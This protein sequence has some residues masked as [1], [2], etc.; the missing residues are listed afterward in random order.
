MIDIYLHCTCSYGIYELHV[1][2]IYTCIL[3]VHT[4]YR[5]HVNMLHNYKGYHVQSLLV[6]AWSAWDLVLLTGR[7]GDMLMSCRCAWI[8]YGGDWSVLWYTHLC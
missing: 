8:Y 6:S 3:H 1:Y 7:A 4:A 5:L 2:M